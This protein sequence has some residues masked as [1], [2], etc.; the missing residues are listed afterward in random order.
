MDKRQNHSRQELNKSHEF[1]PR[2]EFVGMEFIPRLEF[3]GMEFIPH[4]GVMGYGGMR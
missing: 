1:I 2:L 3:V 4:L